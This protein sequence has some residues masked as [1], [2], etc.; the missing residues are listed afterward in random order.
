MS[1]LAHVNDIVVSD[2][3]VDL[4]AGG[5]PSGIPRVASP[6]VYG[7]RWSGREI[8]TR[9]GGP[10]QLCEVVIFDAAEAFQ[11]ELRLCCPR[12]FCFQHFVDTLIAALSIFMGSHAHRPSV[13]G[14]VVAELQI[15]ALLAKAFL[16]TCVRKRDGYCS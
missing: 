14:D 3:V 10:T 2:P 13:H 16:V 6:S 11:C 7:D 1:L 9:V 5:V 15:V 8:V 12:F 4:S